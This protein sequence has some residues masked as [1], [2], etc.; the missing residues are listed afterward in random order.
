MRAVVFHEAGRPQTLE[1]RP[2]PT[3]DVGEVLLEIDLCGVCASDLMAIDGVVTDYSPPVVLGHEVAARV[4]ESRAP[5]VAVGTVTSVNPMISCDV[6]PSCRRGEHKYCPELY[7]IGHDIDGGFADLMVVPRRLVEQG[8]LLSVD[9]GVTPDQLMFVEPL[10]CV[11]N[12]LSDTPARDTM[13]ILGA[14]PIGLLFVQLASSRGARVVVVEPLAHRRDAAKDFGA[15]VV[16]DAT[17]EGIAALLDVT[18]GGADTVIVATDHES[19]LPTAFE[20]VRRGGAIN[21]FG[22]APA[23]RTI[24]LELEQLHFQGHTISASWAF[25]RDSLQEAR[26]MIQDHRIDLAPMVV[27]RFPLEAAN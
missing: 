5:S 6:C 10:G 21:F 14:G 25:S 17:E 20:A 11:I 24:T 9:A 18:D 15:D 1:E 7:G 8:G 23:G 22:L 27:E 19:A 4:V 12:A 26:D 2:T 13:V 3:L 16:V